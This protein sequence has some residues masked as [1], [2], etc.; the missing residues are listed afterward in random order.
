[1]IAVFVATTSISGLNAAIMAQSRL[2]SAGAKRRHLPV[3]LSTI[4]DKYGMP[5]ATS[6]C[7][8][9]LLNAVIMFQRGAEAV[10]EY[11]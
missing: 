11:C 10:C 9:S 4:S 8:V 3:I 2:V 5:W 7:L 6:F 1:M